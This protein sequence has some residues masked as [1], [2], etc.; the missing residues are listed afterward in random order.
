MSHLRCCRDSRQTSRVHLRA[1][2]RGPA[3]GSQQLPDEWRPQRAILLSICISKASNHRKCGKLWGRWH[4][5]ASGR[6][7]EDIDGHWSCQESLPN[8]AC[9][10]LQEQ[11]KKK[12]RMTLPWPPYRTYLFTPPT[13]PLASEASAPVVSDPT[14]PPAPPPRL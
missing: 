8:R 4:S 5:W 3:I 10:H 14:V 6:L 12:I 9:I 11:I 2:H 13:A 1:S 7:H